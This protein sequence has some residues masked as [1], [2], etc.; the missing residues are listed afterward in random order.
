M[1]RATF[2]ANAAEP[3]PPEKPLTDGLDAFA[4]ALEAAGVVPS[5]VEVSLHLDDWRHLARRLDEENPGTRVPGDI[6]WVEVGGIRYLVR[7]GD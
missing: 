5:A 3:A 4:A 7:F 2:A 6:D 1:A